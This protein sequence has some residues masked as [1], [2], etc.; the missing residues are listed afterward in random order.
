MTMATRCTACGTVFRVVPDQLRVSAGWVRCGRCGEAF[1]A[2]EALVDLAA[3]PLVKA[4]DAAAAHRREPV[5]DFA[6]TQPRE[7]AADS[8]E[9]PQPLEQPHDTAPVQ[10]EGMAAGLDVAATV[11]ATS[12]TPAEAAAATDADEDIAFTAEVL[13]AGLRHA[14]ASGFALPEAAPDTAPVAVAED[15]S[16]GNALIHSTEGPQAPNPEPDVAPSA[17][18]EPSPDA[19]ASPADDERR[20][21][22]A[23]VQALEA[24][25]TPVP[26]EA[27]PSPAEPV[28]PAADADEQPAV[29]P[30][31]LRRAE[32]AERWQRPWVRVCLSLAALGAAVG[33]AAQVVLLQ[34]DW[35]AATWPAAKPTL[36]QACTM[37]GCRI[38]E[39]RQIES[40]GVESS[41]LVRIE[42]T[43]MYR[44]S[45]VLRNRAAFELAA[46]AL[47][48]SLTD[49]QGRLIARRVL[50]MGDLGLPLR[51][52]KGGSELPIQ[53][54]LA[55][56]ERPVSGYTVE[57]F[58]P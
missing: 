54:S 14:D 55:V 29:A 15:I 45:V 52:L 57:I 26:T 42:G 12:D 23:A 1:N 10:P 13:A 3:A 7:P 56:A 28:P 19:A 4:A 22:G 47:D 43:S 36:E 34:R 2:A 39:Y 5:A 32:R 33:L 21:P 38:G 17:S 35:L 41:G 27:E 49:A 58:Y 24:L 40:L 8:V 16:A 44:L 25:A 53:A 48:L 50:T 37:L 9:S 20:E 31:F 18:A 6:D 46:P 30:S 11:V 51:T